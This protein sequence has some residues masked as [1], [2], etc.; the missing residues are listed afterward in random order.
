MNR[1]RAMAYDAVEAGADLCAGIAA[2]TIVLAIWLGPWV[3]LGAAIAIG[4]RL[5]G[6]L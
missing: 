2:I 1:L 6:A 4:F 3:L 5:V